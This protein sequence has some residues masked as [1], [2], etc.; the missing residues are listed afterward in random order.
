[1]RMHQDP[2]CSQIE[3]CFT[4]YGEHCFA[5]ELVLK[6][7]SPISL[8]LFHCLLSVTGASNKLCICHVGGWNETTMRNVCLLNLVA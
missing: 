7:V 3:A 5:W 1:M 8:P 6:A 4:A 2:M